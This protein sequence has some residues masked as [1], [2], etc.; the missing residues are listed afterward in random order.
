MPR[1]DFRARPSLLDEQVDSK[2][3]SEI[4][5]GHRIRL[6]LFLII[7]LAYA[8]LIKTLLAFLRSP[9]RVQS[10]I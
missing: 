3:K 10:S 2:A 7:V 8:E 5:P 6:K 9:I 1:R 4:S